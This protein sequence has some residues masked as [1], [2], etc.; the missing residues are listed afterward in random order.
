MVL[1]SDRTSECE[2]G[3]EPFTASEVTDPDEYA[4]LFALAEQ[5]YEGYDDYRER[6]ARVVARFRS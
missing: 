2:F 3:G 5:V 4:R 6:T 1:Q